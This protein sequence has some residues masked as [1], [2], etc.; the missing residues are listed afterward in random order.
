MIRAVIRN[1]RNDVVRGPLH[2]SDVVDLLRYETANGHEF[3]RLG[4]RV[5]QIEDSPLTPEELGTYELL[6]K[7]AGNLNGIVKHFI[8]DADMHRRWQNREPTRED[9]DALADSMRFA[10]DQLTVLARKEHGVKA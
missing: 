7:A 8:F 2:F 4:Q 1:R 5:E 10:A 3:A 6:R 9:I